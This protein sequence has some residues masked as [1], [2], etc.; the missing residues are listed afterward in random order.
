LFTNNMNFSRSACAHYVSLTFN[1][2]CDLDLNERRRSL[3]MGGAT[4]GCEGDNVPPTFEAKG[5]QEVQ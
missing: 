2:T 5:V 4:A 3:S 1:L